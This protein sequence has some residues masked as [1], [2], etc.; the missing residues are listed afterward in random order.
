MVTR[1][2]DSWE[3]VSQELSLPLKA[4]QCYSFSLEIS[5]SERYLSPSRLY[6]GDQK[7]HNYTRPVVF[8][9]WGGYGYCGTAELLAESTP[10]NNSPW[11]TFTFKLSPKANYRYIT[12][13]AFYKVP[14]VFP[15][16][17]HILVDN[18]SQIIQ[19]NCEDEL[20][21]VEDIP[22]K[23]LPPHK[24]VKKKP[25]A[26]VNKPAKRIKKLSRTHNLKKRF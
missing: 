17:G 16:N 25:K 6:E 19:I 2:N 11:K 21:V 23:V 20:A 18:C 7:Q 5:R 10:V 24:R 22:E 15:Y 3:S 26:Q 1:D 4:G 9:L 13:E 8:R 14:V 12:F